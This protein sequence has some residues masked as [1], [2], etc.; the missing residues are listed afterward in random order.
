MFENVFAFLVPI[1]ISAFCWWMVLKP[2][3]G[4]RFGKPGYEFWR[5]NE[6]GRESW[7]AMA[8]AAYLIGAVFF[9]LLTLA[10]LVVAILVGK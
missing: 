3:T 5:F 8:L 6:E 2:S 9:S 10:F 7:D 1:G 4:R